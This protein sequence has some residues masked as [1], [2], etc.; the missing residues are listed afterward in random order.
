MLGLSGVIACSTSRPIRFRAL[1]HL[2]SR[3]SFPG[4]VPD[5]RSGSLLRAYEDI[6]RS[7]RS[8]SDLHTLEF[9]IVPV[10]GISSDDTDLQATGTRSSA[11]THKI[12]IGDSGL[13]NVRFGPLCGP[14]SDISQGPRSARIGLMHCNKR[15]GLFNHLV[16][17]DK[18]PLR[19]GDAE[20][21]RGLEVDQ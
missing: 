13:I 19:Q 9:G 2:F 15:G 21:P 1:V 11:C 6:E 12:A 8:D 18:Q 10:Q 17:A 3:T 7:S 16:G 4:L 14:K 20:G 5:S